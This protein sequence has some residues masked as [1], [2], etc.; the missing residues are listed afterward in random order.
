MA[1]DES[2]LKDIQSVVDF[3]EK[4]M[5]QADETIS[6]HY[7]DLRKNAETELLESQKRDAERLQEE[8]TRL[9]AEGTL[10]SEREALEYAKKKQTQ[11]NLQS[12]KEQLDILKDISKQSTKSDAKES[13]KLDKQ[14][15]FQK[16]IN[17][18]RSD[19][20]EDG[21]KKTKL[22]KLGG[23]VG[24]DLKETFSKV[25]ASITDSL[26]NVK[27]TLKNGFA[28]LGNSINSAITTY[29]NYRGGINARLQGTSYDNGSGTSAFTTLSDKLDAVSYSGLLST[30]DLYSNLQSL[31]NSGIASNV[32][33]LALLQTM[34]D[35][36]APTF[37]TTNKTLRQLV[38]V[39]QQDSTAARMGMEAYLTKFLNEFVETTEY[40]TDTFDSV[41]DALYEA[42]AL[43]SSSSSSEF[44]YIVQ[45][46]LGTLTGVGLSESTATSIATAIGQLGS[47]NISAL[48]SS[49]MQNLIVMAASRS[50]SSYAE[51]LSGGLNATSV[52]ALMYSL[53]DFLQ[54]LNSSSN[55]NVVKSQLASTYGVSITDLKAV[56]NLGSQELTSLYNNVMTTSDMYG[57]LY[58]Q[59]SSLTD[60]LGT[61]KILE[62]LFSNY[63]FST[64]MNIANNPALYALWKISDL[65]E[66]TTG[67][68]NLPVISAFGNS[69]DL[70][71]TLT[72]LMKLGIVG[73]ST[74]GGIGDIISGVSSIADGSTLLSALDISTNNT[75]IT[76]GSGLK[77]KSRVSGLSTSQSTEQV[78]TSS[79]DDFYNQSLNDSKQTVET[80]GEESKEENVDSTAEILKFLQNECG[81]GGIFK[82]IKS[83]IHSMATDGVSVKNYGLTSTL[84]GFN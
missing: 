21:T 28:N 41:A 18:L 83:D 14:I 81:D 27:D 7:K 77:S 26:N 3:Y 70:K 56:S 24:A 53:V 40:L 84:Q 63:E 5:K 10:S 39:Q 6:K 51:L 78:S 42:S 30:E 73:A 44:E 66:S 4:L 46:W 82:D 64:G 9:R 79:G 37:D 25:G 36:I 1:M 74:L 34:K 54:E 69:V 16:D 20:N 8:I 38:R 35:T 43:M 60:R 58:S 72:Q 52:N 31:V 45:K 71:A 65:V 2:G 13:K 55:S 49:D 23:T 19:Y 12:K 17:K 50:G 33:Q 48:S 59:F 62:N 11:N 80:L 76:R 57:E 75:S 61:E 32:D 29:S 22:Q 67:G 68:I 15:K 47:G